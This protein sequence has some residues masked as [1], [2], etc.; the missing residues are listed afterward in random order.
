M[1]KK[2]LRE[3]SIED[4]NK[5]LHASLQEQFNLRMQK[6]S[7]QLTRTDGHKK[8]RRKIARIHTLLNEKAG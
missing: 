7:G 3:M 8:L 5:E 1:K 4:L 6:A 2:S